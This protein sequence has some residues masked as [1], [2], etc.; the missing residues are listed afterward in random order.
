MN[1]HEWLKLKNWAVIGASEKHTSYGHKITKKLMSHGF[2]TIPVAK[3]YEEVNGVKAYASLLDYDG[4]I[5]VVDFVVNPRIGLHVLDDVIKK[6]I[7]KIVLQ[8][9]TVSEAVIDKAKA[10]NIEV[11]EGCVLVMLAWK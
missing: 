9:G 3:G 6:G 10:N 1:Q 4:E 11:L 7:K 2:T 8:P 5:D